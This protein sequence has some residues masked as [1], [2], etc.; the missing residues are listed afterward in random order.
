MIPSNNPVETLAELRATLDAARAE[1]RSVGLVP[2][3]GALHEG[4]LSLV[5]R[6]VAENDLTVLTVFVNP[7]QFRPGEDL[8]AYPRQLE[9]DIALATERGADLVFAPSVNEVYP[10]GFST[11]VAVS[12]ITETLCGAPERRGHEHFDGV[13]TVVA[14]LFNMVG[15]DRAYFGQKDA[16]QV[17]VIRRMARDLNVRTSIVACP[18]VRE[19]DGLALSS[20]N[21]YLSESDRPRALCLSRALRVAAAALAAGNADAAELSAL[22][23]AELNDADSVEYFELVDPDSLQPVTTVDR[24]VLAAVCARVGDTRLIDNTLLVPS[25]ASAETPDPNSNATPQTL[26]GA[27]L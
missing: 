1:G 16:Q 19:A 12:G 10:E 22:A 24:P 21:A 4:H 8:D 2:T 18:T 13:T 5:D 17:A 27:A 3:M 7:T 15:A 14:K 9:N 11:S 23:L 26:Q 25:P 20:R 6:S